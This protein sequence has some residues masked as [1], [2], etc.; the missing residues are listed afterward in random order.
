MKGMIAIGACMLVCLALLSGCTNEKDVNSESDL[1]NSVGIHID[2][3]G[4]GD[5]EISSDDNG[6][7]YDFKDPDN[8]DGIVVAPRE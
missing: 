6:I 5:F 7:V 2:T 8:T 3:E 1:N 4:K